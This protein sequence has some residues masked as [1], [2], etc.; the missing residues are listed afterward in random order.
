VGYI[1]TSEAFGQRG[2]EI[3]T[4]RSSKLAPDAGNIL[5][6]EVLELVKEFTENLN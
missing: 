5:T 2:Y 6:R 4:A 1:P 3:K